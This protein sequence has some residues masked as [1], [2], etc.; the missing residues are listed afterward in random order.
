MNN[1]HDSAYI[2]R[3]RSSLRVPSPEE[4]RHGVETICDRFGLVSP[5]DSGVKNETPSTRR[6]GRTRRPGR[7]SRVVRRLAVSAEGVGNHLVSRVGFSALGL[8]AAATVLAGISA[9]L[10]VR[11]EFGWAA[12]ALLVAGFF[13]AVDA[14]AARRS[15][16]DRRDVYIDYLSDR[17]SDVLIFGSLWL[18]LATD[19]GMASTMSAVVLL[20]S[21]LSSYARAQAEALRFRSL[22]HFGRLERL[23]VTTVLLAGVWAF[24]GTGSTA[25]ME[26]A[27]WIL[28]FLTSITLF[29]LLE[30]IVTVVRSREALT[31]DLSGPGWDE[32]DILPRL[33]GGLMESNP[34]LTVYAADEDS[35]IGQLIHIRR[36]ASGT[37]HVMVEQ[38]VS[39]QDLRRRRR[40]G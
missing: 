37:A 9:W 14:V 38:C 33:L 24:G 12:L 27:N 39:R 11:D 30:R 10:I 4:V 19:H 13:E 5:T 36:S 8:T 35:E 17:V 29:T 25:A 7:Y 3:E 2:L 34:R 20:L 26:F 18:S 16:S 28:L 32:S 31:L 22:S 15:V 21:L 40:A 6:S 23:A 1:R